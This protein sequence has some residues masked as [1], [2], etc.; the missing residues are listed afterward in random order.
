MCDIREK[1]KKLRVKLKEIRNSI[2]S[3][4]RI[5]K[6]KKA[7]KNL[8]SSNLEIK[9][10]NILLFMTMGTEIDT[11]DFFEELSKIAKKIYIP[12]VDIKRN[13]MDICEYDKEAKLEISNYKV[14][15]PSKNTKAEDAKKI[16]IILL[17]GL[18]FTNSGARI[19]YGGG[20]YDKFIETTRKDCKLIGL[21]FKE[22]IV[23]EIPLEEFDARLHY[24]LS[25]DSL[26]K[27][28]N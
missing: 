15:E 13:F 5:Q 9:N 10:K 7:L 6:S 2:P 1:K 18:G 17:P 22:Q 3:E 26:Q 20:F 11:G 19:G 21:C 28:K 23:D 12:R 27:V 4:K 16:D 14:P 8:L 24:I 25:D